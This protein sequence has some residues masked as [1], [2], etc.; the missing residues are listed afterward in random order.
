V[1]GVDDEDVTHA[2][3]LGHHVRLPGADRPAALR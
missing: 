2:G 1:T 3:R